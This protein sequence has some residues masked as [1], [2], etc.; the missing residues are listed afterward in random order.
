LRPEGGRCLDV[1]SVSTS[2]PPDGKS[3]RF[4]SGPLSE[5]R[6]MGHRVHTSLVFCGS[7]PGRALTRLIRTFEPPKV[8]SSTHPRRDSFSEIDFGSTALAPHISPSW[9][10]NFR[11]R[12]LVWSEALART[13]IGVEQNAEKDDLE[14]HTIQILDEPRNI[15]AL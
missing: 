8:P 3:M 6:D 11:S 13:Y 12:T 7:P 5:N 2:Q 14:T 10:N 9:C 15:L 1:S 4:V